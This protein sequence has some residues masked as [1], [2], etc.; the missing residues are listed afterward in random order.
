MIHSKDQA[1]CGIQYPKSPHT[2]YCKE[3]YSP[4]KQPATPPARQP[5]HAWS[6]VMNVS[7]VCNVNNLQTYGRLGPM[8]R[9]LRATLIVSDSVRGAALLRRDRMV[10]FARACSCVR[11]NSGVLEVIILLRYILTWDPIVSNRRPDCKQH[12]H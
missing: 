9:C 4:A 10:C 11:M 6:C 7:Y 12:C 3:S 8:V 5:C 2:D 1:S